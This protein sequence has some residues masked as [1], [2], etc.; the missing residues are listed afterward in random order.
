MK[1]GFTMHASSYKNMEKF[2]LKYLKEYKDQEIK[3]IDI[4]SQDINGTYKPLFQNSKWTY[5]GCDM[6]K[7]ENVDIVIDNVYDWKDIKSGTFD[8]VISGQAFEHIEYFWVTI[9]EIAR[10]LKNGGLSCIIAPSGGTEHRYPV[11]CWRYYPDGF[12]A[13]ARYAGLKTIDVY[14]QWNKELYPDY[15]PVWKDSV[16]I[17]IKPE[18]TNCQKLKF[19][20]KNKLSKFLINLNIF[21]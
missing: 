2:V 20:L 8:V 6:V 9:L 11:D 5:V 16:L 12:K 7:G 3:I 19:Y 14:T 4:G 18:L 15:D 21:V 1:W 17:C 10:I 13:L